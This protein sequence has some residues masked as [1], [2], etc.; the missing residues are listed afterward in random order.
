MEL[1]NHLQF[2]SINVGGVLNEL[3]QQALYVI[4]AI[5]IFLGILKFFKI[6]GKGAI[7]VFFVGSVVYFCIKYTD[8]V[9][10]SLAEFFSK[11]F[12]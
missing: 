6:G 12:N 2:M 11:I 7:G 3:R 8:S 1:L 5:V 9:F 4:S 10:N